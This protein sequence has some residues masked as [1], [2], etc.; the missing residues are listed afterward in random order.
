MSNAVQTHESS[1]PNFLA[2]KDQYFH[3][4]DKWRNL[5][6][7]LATNVGNGVWSRIVDQVASL[8]PEW[9]VRLATEGPN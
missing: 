1:K 7:D 2:E 3:E 4:V 6:S 8:V 5:H 9:D